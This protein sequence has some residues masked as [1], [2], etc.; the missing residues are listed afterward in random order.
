M[1]KRYKAVVTKGNCPY[2]YLAPKTILGEGYK[3][4]INMSLYTSVRNW[5]Q[6]IHDHLKTQK[7]YNEAVRIR[8][9]L[10]EF[11]HKHLKAQEKS[12]ISTWAYEKLQDTTIK[13]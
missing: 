4:S 12:K 5:I 13:F 10:L 6:E 2:S 9:C 7:M 3:V 1:A 11:V 8:T